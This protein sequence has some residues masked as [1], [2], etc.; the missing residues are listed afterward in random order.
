MKR[1]IQWAIYSDN[2]D[3]LKLPVEK[4]KNKVVCDLHFRIESFM[5]ISRG[6]L[7]RTTAIPT[8]YIGADKM[9]VDLEKY[10]L[11]WVIANKQKDDPETLDLKCGEP[12]IDI[13]ES[14]NIAEST[15]NENFIISSEILSPPTKRIK[16]E[17]NSYVSQV[18]IL[19][20][21]ASLASPSTHKVVVIKKQPLRLPLPIKTSGKQLVI[22]KTPKTPPVVPVPIGKYAITDIAEESSIQKVS[23]QDIAEMPISIAEEYQEHHTVDQQDQSER[24]KSENEDLQ[25]LLLNVL[26]KQFSEVKTMISEKQAI[27]AI[28]ST[29]P[30]TAKLESANISQSHLNKVQLFN[31]I[32][33]YLSPSITAL[34][35]MELFSLPGREYKKD[36]KIICSELLKLGDETYEFLSQ[37]W[38]LRL[39]SK[40]EVNQ[41]ISEQ[42]L[43]DDEN[44]A[45]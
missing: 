44:D 36:E 25:P 10:P 30:T 11:E 3:F 1:C 17:Q 33:R 7:N 41:W 38:R 16:Q 5:N 31:G 37:E 2:M 4:L 35:R 22:T 24:L 14:I 43:V 19:N 42:S 20:K 12:Q 21:N 34:L 15:S 45:S 23:S 13:D 8:I 18:R 28:A 6:K 39:P 32:K 26:L 29:S 27:A 40:D 9:E